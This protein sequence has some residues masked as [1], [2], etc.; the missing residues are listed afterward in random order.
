MILYVIEE[1]GYLKV[2]VTKD[3]RRRFKELQQANPRPLRIIG[4]HEVRNGFKVE[5]LVLKHCAAWRVR[6][7]AEWLIDGKATRAAI[8]RALVEYKGGDIASTA[9]LR[10][11]LDPCAPLCDHDWVERYWCTYGPNR[12]YWTICS[13]CDERGAMRVTSEAPER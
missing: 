1:D 10:P 2:G 8:A 4:Q 7:R 13:K 12:W 11:W 3:L 5:S 9:S 6:E